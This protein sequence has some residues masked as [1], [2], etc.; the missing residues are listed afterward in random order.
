MIY[1]QSAITKLQYSTEALLILTSEIVMYE[2]K[3]TPICVVISIFQRN[4]FLYHQLS[5]N[6]IGYNIFFNLLH[7]VHHILERII[8]EDCRCEENNL[9]DMPHNNCVYVHLT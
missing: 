5:Y 4:G 6:H 9:P 8:I 7:R 2:C 1:T 3:R